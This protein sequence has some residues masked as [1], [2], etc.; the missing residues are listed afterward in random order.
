M[1]SSSAKLTAYEFAKLADAQVGKPYVL[2]AEASLNDNNPPKFD[3]SELVEWLFGRNNTP[4]GDLAAWQFDKTKA[5]TGSPKVGD[6]VFLRNNPARANRIGHVAVL[7]SKL[8]NGDW[9]I[10]E[11]RGRASG[12]V[13]TTLSY[14]KTR[15]YFTG[16]R[17]YPG[18]MLKTNQPPIPVND[19]MRVGSFN[20]EYTAWGGNKNY[21]GDG[22]FVKNTLRSSITFLQEADEA[23]RNAIRDVL[24]SGRYKTWP[25]GLVSVVWDSAKY[26]FGEH[27]ALSFGTLANRCME[28]EL[29]S[30]ENG[31]QFYVCSIHVRSR[32][33][34]PRSWSNEKKDAAKLGDIRDII[35]FLKNRKNVIVGGDW[36]T[37]AARALM[38]AAG[39]RL[40]TPWRGTHGASKIDAIYVRGNGLVVRNIHKD[41]GFRSGGPGNIHT[42]KGLS[43]HSAVLANLTRVDDSAL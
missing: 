22:R 18:F 33:A 1:P 40:A 11:A 29:F 5:V 23:A 36:N 21:S 26:D 3:C 6:L 9:R 16:V 24:G 43:D 38:E 25:T 15:K 39:Y 30:K 17:R 41:G 27:R 20:C 34:F 4:I 8:S 14:W 42:A 35:K 37:S 7:T 31:E 19:D 10:I 32:D 2:G 12:V 13:R 28:V